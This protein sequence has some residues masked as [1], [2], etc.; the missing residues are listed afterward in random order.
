MSPKQR[1][2]YSE[3]ED[4]AMLELTDDY[5]DGTA[6]PGVHAMRCRQI[7][8]HPEFFGLEVGMTGKDEM[9]DIHLEN[10]RNTGEPLIIFSALVPEMQRIFKLVHAKG[11]KVGLINGSTSMKDRV[12][13]DEAFRAGKLQVIVASPATAGVGFN[14][15]IC[16]RIVYCSMDYQDSSFFQSYRR[17][18]RGKRKTPLAIHVL[19]YRDSI[20]ERILQVVER[21]SRLANIIDE[22]KEIYAL[23]SR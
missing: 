12:L 7:C 13:F 3:F 22:T 18:I 5:L 2:A 20:E 21:K 14:W 8:A 11:M 23:N 10:H 9:L 16:N 6:S 19:C 17:A 4:K 15:E 1:A